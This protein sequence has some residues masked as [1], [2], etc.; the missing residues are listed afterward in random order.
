MKGRKYLSPSDSMQAFIFG[1]LI[2]LAM[3]LITSVIY[4]GVR[5]AGG[6]DTAVLWIGTAT[7]TASLAVV[8]ALY[9]SAKNI[10]FFKATT[11]NVKPKLSSVFTGMLTVVGL[12]FAL[13]PVVF[14][15]MTFLEQHG[16]VVESAVDDLMPKNPSL[17]VIIFFVIVVCVLPAFC[18]EVLMR[19]IIAKGFGRWG[20]VTASLL[21]G[22]IFMLLHMSPAQTIYQFALGVILGIFMLHGGSIWTVIIMHFFNNF[23]SVILDLVLSAEIQTAIFVNYW[24][25]SMPLGALVAVAG[26]MLFIKLTANAFD[27]DFE[28][29]QRQLEIDSV[30]LKVDLVYQEERLPAALP[31]TGTLE[32]FF[33]AAA[34]GICAAMW[35]LNL[36]APL[37]SQ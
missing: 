11:L 7:A 28:L 9:A 22:F 35:L 21:S 26:I 24:Y 2:F 10:N 1:L 19:G 25:I 6:Q 27:K 23:L 33:F 18:E 32:K 3:S 31:K 15:F 34:L 12:I 17:M 14:A 29:K 37:I 13:L 4:A 30:P 5:A 36:F 16:L 20:I 8:C